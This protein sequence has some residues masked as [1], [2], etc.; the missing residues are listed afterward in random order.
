MQSKTSS[1]LYGWDITAFYDDIAAMK[2][3]LILHCKK[4]CFQQEA[5]PTTG[6][7]HLQM[8]ISLNDKKYEASV[9]KMFKPFN[10]HISRSST[11]TFQKFTKDYVTKDLTRVAGPWAYD[12]PKPAYVPIQYRVAKLRPWQDQVKQSPVDPRAV[13]IIL[14]PSG[15]I[16][17]S[18]CVG[19]LCCTGFAQCIPFC[20]DFRDIM[21]TIMDKP[22]SSIYLIDLPRAIK[23]D[24]L[25]QMY[26]GIEIIKNGY[27]YDDRYKFRE[28]WFDTPSIWVFTNILPDREMLSTDRWRIWNIVDEQ[29]VPHSF[30][31]IP[32]ASKS[33]SLA[34]LQLIK[35]Q[36]K[37]GKHIVDVDAKN[38][39]INNIDDQ[40]DANF[41]A[42]CDKIAN[43]IS[44]E[45]EQLTEHLDWI[46]LSEDDPVGI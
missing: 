30:D 33:F 38:T 19:V 39:L 3:F 6:K 4:W 14:D 29:L 1:Q 13:N 42:E 27:C 37:Q 8:K 32:N 12:D 10:A 46:L 36:A 35:V 21:R 11:S 24:K 31:N 9:I 2:E 7:L 23:K 43:E 26:A 5:C 15:N 17:K 40:Y 16:G 20:N 45:S 28:E 44:E 18:V 25:F 34:E 41:N 22:K